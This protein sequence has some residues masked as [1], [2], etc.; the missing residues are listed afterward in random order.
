M[1][2]VEFIKER[3]RMCHYQYHA[4]GR[5]GCRDCSVSRFRQFDFGDSCLIQC[6]RFESDMP[7]LFVAVVEEWGKSHPVD[8]V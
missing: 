8:G 4:P 3:E 2:A 7:E 5:Y 1:D 6:E